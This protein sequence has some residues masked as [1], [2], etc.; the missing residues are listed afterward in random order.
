MISKEPIYKKETKAY[1][2][3]MRHLLSKRESVE[4][5]TYGETI[6]MNSII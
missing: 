2:S 3:Q 5:A 1:L 6:W 4:E